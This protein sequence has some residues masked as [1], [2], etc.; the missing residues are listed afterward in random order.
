ML[1]VLRE[2]GRAQRLLMIL[3]VQTSSRFELLGIKLVDRNLVMSNS[4]AVGGFI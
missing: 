3:L 2:K 1:L 4:A